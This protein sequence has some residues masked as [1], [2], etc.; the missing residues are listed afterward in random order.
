M[1]F[2]QLVG[3]HHADAGG[4]RERAGEEGELERALGGLAAGPGV[5]LL[6]ARVVVDVADRQR[7]VAADSRER[8]R[9]VGR[10]RPGAN[11]SAGRRADTGA[12][13]AGRS[14]S[15]G[16]GCR[17]AHAP[18]IR[19]PHL[20]ADWAA[21]EVG[22]PVAGDA[23]REDVVVRALD[24]V[25]RVDLHVA[26]VLDRG[27]HRRRA[28]RRKAPRRRAR[29]ARSASR[30]ASDRREGERG[31]GHA[32]SIGPCRAPDYHSRREAAPRARAGRRDRAGGGDRGLARRLGA[33]RRRW[34]GGRCAGRGG[35]RRRWCSA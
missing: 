15:R 19:T 8:S 26:E 21:R 22:A 11:Q 35:S 17:R 10:R 33:E 4:D 14:G 6:D 32:A 28:R 20:S 3:L 27:A 29:W 30:R 16:S 23:G 24:H 2:G 7:A 13:P 34:R 31:A 5:V 1:A 12:S 9:S 25:D 18:S